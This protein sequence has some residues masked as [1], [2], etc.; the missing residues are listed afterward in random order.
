MSAPSGRSLTLS[1]QASTRARE[2]LLKGR[3]RRL[4]RQPALDHLGR[5]VAR[6]RTRERLALAGDALDVFGVEGRGLRRNSLGRVLDRELGERG[7]GALS[8]VLRDLVLV[9]RLDLRLELG[10]RVAARS[11]GRVGL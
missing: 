1:G 11:V 10:P 4:R 2:P 6:R 3:P 8:F 9:P 7:V 5:C